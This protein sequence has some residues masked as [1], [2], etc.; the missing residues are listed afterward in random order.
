[1]AVEQVV[2]YGL[3]Q[4]RVVGNSVVVLGDSSV[5]VM[6][7]LSATDLLLL[8]ALFYSLLSPIATQHIIHHL[9]TNPHRMH[10][11][12]PLIL[13]YIHHTGHQPHYPKLH[14]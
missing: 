14:Q 7:V 11:P 3:Q 13:S 6:V 8:L 5:M 4:V 2:A 9:Q 10:I 12:L 1:M